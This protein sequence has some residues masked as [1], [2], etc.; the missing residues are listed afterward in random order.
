MSEKQSKCDAKRNEW[1]FAHDFLFTPQLPVYCRRCELLNITAYKCCHSIFVGGI[2][3][4]LLQSNCLRRSF[5]TI[6]LQQPLPHRFFFLR[7]K[8]V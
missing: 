2:G 6:A 4:R 3:E 8:L 5:G 7:I 1:A